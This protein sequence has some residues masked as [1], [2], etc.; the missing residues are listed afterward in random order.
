MTP[1]KI[2][3]KETV[4]SKNSPSEKNVLAKQW[5]YGLNINWN[6]SNIMSNSV[7]D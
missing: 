1:E 3:R 2:L 4:A 6:L 7:D 5:Q